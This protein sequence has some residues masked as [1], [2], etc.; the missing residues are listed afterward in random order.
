MTSLVEGMELAA[1]AR[2]YA[3][4]AE[5][6]FFNLAI[7][8]AT[9]S[10]DEKRLTDKREKALEDAKMAMIFLY[11]AHVSEISLTEDA[12]KLLKLTVNLKYLLDDSPEG[13]KR[14]LEKVVE[15]ADTNIAAILIALAEICRDN[16]KRYPDLA[17]RWEKDA[18][19]LEHAINL[20]T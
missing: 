9:N 17:H 16:V 11:P 12:E 3:S 1:H 8:S 13:I 2:L 4:L 15:L 19:V 18:A 14:D 5:S 6:L 10:K 20:V 7:V